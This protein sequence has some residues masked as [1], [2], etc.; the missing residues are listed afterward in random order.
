MTTTVYCMFNFSMLSVLLLMLFCQVSS[1]SW[2][3]IGST[4]AAGW[5]SPWQSG[6]KKPFKHRTNTLP[7]AFAQLHKG[8][9]LCWGGWPDHGREHFA[10]LANCGADNRR[11]ADVSEPV[12]DTVGKSNRTRVAWAMRCHIRELPYMMSPQN[13]CVGWRNVPDLWRN[14]VT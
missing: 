13:V 14:T 1:D 4:I 3:I 7:F 11:R 8:M 10:R 6:C 9:G 5:V 12:R 2:S